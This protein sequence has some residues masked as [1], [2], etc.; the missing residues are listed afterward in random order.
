MDFI[1]FLSKYV[2]YFDYCQFPLPLPLSV[3]S[4]PLHVIYVYMHHTHTHTLPRFHL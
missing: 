4:L 1:V 2:M 3:S